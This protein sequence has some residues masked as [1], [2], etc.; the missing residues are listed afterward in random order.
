[1]TGEQAS[2]GRRLR[3]LLPGELDEEQRTVYESITGGPRA[4]GPSH[5]PLV[6][7]EGRLHGPF[8]AMLRSPAVGGALQGLGSALRYG[9]DLPARIREMAILA[10]A[11]AE[12]SAF[13]RFAHEA[14]GRGVGLSDEE[15]G[16]LRSEAPLPG[17]DPVEAAAVRAVRSLLRDGDLDDPT[18]GSTLGALGERA[19][20]EL[21]AV[22][23]YY[24]TLAM[25]LRVFRVPVPDGSGSARDDGGHHLT[26]L[27]DA[28]DQPIARPQ[29]DGRPP[30]VAHPGRG[31]GEDEVSG[32]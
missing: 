8:D 24:R 26:D 3:P 23:G 4:S 13:E 31:A 19:L 27:P 21:T 16:C 22:V 5:F 29:V 32:Q 20:F 9:S 28:A 25:Q 30:R 18:F 14:V 11:A 12:D 15:L 10:V 17:D 1:V 6:D 2:T 7:G